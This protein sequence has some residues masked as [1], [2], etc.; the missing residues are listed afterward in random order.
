[1]PDVFDTFEEKIKESEEEMCSDL[2]SVNV[3][4]I[5]S[6][7]V[8]L[9]LG[10]KTFRFTK[11]EA[12][13]EENVESIIRKEFKEKI[14]DQLTRIREKINNKVVQMQL[15]YQQMTD[16]FKRKERKLQSKYKNSA[17]MP[18]ISREHFCKNLSVFKGDDQGELV[19]MY[20]CEYK[21]RFMIIYNDPL[22][23]EPRK[24]RRALPKRMVNRLKKPMV[25]EI[26]TKADQIINIITK[27]HNESLNQL[28][29]MEHYHRSGSGNCWGTWNAYLNASWKTPDDILYWMKEAEGVIETINYGSIADSSPDGLP[30]A[31]TVKKAAENE[32]DVITDVRE[33]NDDED[34][35]DVS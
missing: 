21:P 20:R 32:G 6:N 3:D 2:N 34:A 26:T 10:G 29:N 30:R 35:W 18:Q 12:V 27:E 23:N 28:I 22:G 17:M 4:D 25:I 9:T 5:N 31:A 24:V 14:N 11:V 15:M 13:E 16:E 8:R 33:E 19:W 1:M 7:D